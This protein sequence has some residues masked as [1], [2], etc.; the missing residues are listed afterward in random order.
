M[1]YAPNH[2]FAKH[3]IENGIRRF[4][5]RAEEIQ[6]QLTKDVT[7][8]GYGYNGMTPGPTLVAFEGERVQI[9]L[10]NRLSE[11]TS[12]HW[13]GL[14]IPDD[15]DGVPVIGAGPLIK[16]GETF[17]YDFTLKQSG[18][19]M[20]HTHVNDAKQELLGLAGMFIILPK[21]PTHH[22]DRDYVILLQEWSLNL[23]EMSQNGNSMAMGSASSSNSGSGNSGMSRKTYTADPESMMFNFFTINGKAY[24]ST[25]PLWV[26]EGE[27]IRLR[28][29]NLSM[30][31]HPMHLHGHN[32]RVVATDGQTLPNPY[33]K[34][35]IN[36]APGETYDVEFIANNPGAWA[37]H[38]HKP[39]HTTNGHQT[40]MG[41]MFTAVQYIK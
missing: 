10:E 13:H 11:A 23:E 38:C 30:D 31:S 28:V 12:V 26:K 32:Y 15:M 18:T 17:F 14:I 34:N 27:R 3:E 2:Q 19:Y 22:I 36:V 9:V 16:A 41:G 35:T 1:L 25:E 6:Q 4:H 5:L 40:D 39:H 33:Y 20:Y 7:I 29:G 24:P 8:K 21:T 37:F